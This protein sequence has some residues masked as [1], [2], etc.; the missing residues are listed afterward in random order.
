MDRRVVSAVL[1]V[2]ACVAL[3]ACSGQTG[4]ATNV[5]DTSASLHASGRTDA[6]PG[7][8][9]FQY[10]K[11]AAA[12]G[13]T[14]GVQTPTRGPFPAHVPA[15]GT[16]DFAEAVTGLSPATRYYYRVCGGDASIHPDVCMSTRTFTTEPSGG[17]PYA[18]AEPGA[19]WFLVPSGVTQVSLVAKGAQ[20]GEGVAFSQDNPA[21]AVVPGGHGA[22]ARAQIAVGEGDRLE[23]L[24]GRVGGDGD[25]GTGHGGAGGSNGSDRGGDGGAGGDFVGTGGAGGG[26]APTRVV[27]FPADGGI[28]QTVLTAGGGGGGGAALDVSGGAAGGDAG[29]AG[30]AGQDGYDPAP[31][32][33]T[34]SHGGGGT[35]ASAAGAGGAPGGGDGASGLGGGGA[36]NPYVVNS[37]AGLGGGGGG[38]GLFGGGG[39]GSGQWIVGPVSDTEVEGSGGGGG[40]SFATPS[41]LGTP[42]FVTSSA[43]GPG[44]VVIAWSAAGGT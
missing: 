19:S 42:S 26:G 22:V 8:Y 32:D 6:S 12:L 29:L 13:T 35:T 3:A 33:A 36:A 11:S 23:L 43:G 14:A 25:P 31:G 24:V 28:A 9:E 27:L 30:Q 4:P 2:A 39:G 34:T 18:T 20:G 17:S 38:G 41:A 40:S 15:S 37:L 1:G 21:G 44:L 16:I 10:A 5:T 7:H